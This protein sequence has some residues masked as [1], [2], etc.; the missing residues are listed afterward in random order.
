M[1][2]MTRFFQFRFLKVAFIP[3]AAAATEAAEAA[4]V[5]AATAEAEALEVA[6]AVSSY[7]CQF[8]SYNTG[9][10]LPVSV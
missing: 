6:A 7:K 2:R 10:L 3:E 8:S 9:S 1:S 4:E 5:A